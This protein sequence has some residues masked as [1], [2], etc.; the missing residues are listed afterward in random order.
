MYRTG[1]ATLPLHDGKD[2]V[3]FPVNRAAM[4]ESIEVLRKT[5]EAAKIGEKER[6]RSLEGLRRF[7]PAN[8]DS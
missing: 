4:D 7:V 8:A 3:P 2:G 5:V 1:T 6:L